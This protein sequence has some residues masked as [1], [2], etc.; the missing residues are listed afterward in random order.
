M[1]EVREGEGV[2][3]RSSQND[4]VGRLDIC[5]LATE[6]LGLGKLDTQ[7]DSLH[8]LAFCKSL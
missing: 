7:P 2:V 1:S 8:P 3:W 4:R 6:A 5:L